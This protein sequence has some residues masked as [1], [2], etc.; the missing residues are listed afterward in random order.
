M[1]WFNNLKIASKLLLSFSIAIVL[2]IFLGVFS[3]VQLSKVNEAATAVATNWLPS[4]QVLG[5]VKMAMARIR[6]FEQQHILATTPEDMQTAE[7]NAV[8]QIEDLISLQKKYES[9]ISEEEEKKIYPEVAKSITVF[10]AEHAKI[11]EYSSKRTK[12]EAITLMR[13]EST[14]VYRAMLAE[15]DKL[16]DVNDAGAEKSSEFAGKT[17]SD[18]R[19]WII[20]LIIVIAVL[21]FT[22][23]YWIAR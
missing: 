18:S 16:A 12:E 23:A 4:I 9:L 22:F 14:K 13:G 19:T 11:V 21:S 10:L 8:K 7:K 20:V 15:V 5:R 1:K 6:S 3:I 17:Y 2:S